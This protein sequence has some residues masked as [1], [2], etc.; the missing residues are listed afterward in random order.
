[1]LEVFRIDISIEH[2]AFMKINNPTK[3]EVTQEGGRDMYNKIL[4]PLDGSARAEDI[5]PHVMELASKYQSTT[6]RKETTKWRRS[7]IASH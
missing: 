5:L 7:K 2:A 1:M 3:N 4:V 6:K